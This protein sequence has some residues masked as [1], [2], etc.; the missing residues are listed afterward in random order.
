MISCWANFELTDFIISI[1]WFDLVISK[2]LNF[3]FQFSLVKKKKIYETLNKIQH[4]FFS[5][6]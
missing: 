5:P 3:S 4:S 2:I 1:Q 6:W